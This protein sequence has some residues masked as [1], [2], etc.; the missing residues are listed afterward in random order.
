[1][2]LRIIPT[3]KNA[4]PP[5]V[6]TY[7]GEFGIDLSDLAPEQVAMFVAARNAARYVESLELPVASK[8]EPSHGASL[9]ERELEMIL[10][11]TAHDSAYHETSLPAD[12]MGVGAIGSSHDL[13]RLFPTQWLLE[14]VQPTLFYHKLADGELL[15]P[16]WQR[17]SSGCHN[18]YDD[19]PARDLIDNAATPTARRQHAY[20]L[21]DVSRSMN[22]RDRRG[23]V[24]RGLALA[25]LR[26]G[27]RGRCHLNCRPFNA[28]VQAL[29]SGRGEGALEQLARRIIAL[30]NAGQ[31]RIQ[32][33]LETA[34]QDVR[35][36]GPCRRADIML[37]SDGISR[38]TRCPLSR[39]ALHT[40][41][42]GELPESSREPRQ[43]MVLPHE[44]VNLSQAAARTGDPAS[45]GTEADSIAVLEGW[46]KSFHQVGAPEFTRLLTPS[47][48]DV[49]AA[50][51]LLRE[52]ME[53]LDPDSTLDIADALHRLHRNAAFLLEQWKRIHGREHSLPEEE[54]TLKQ[55]LASAAGHDGS[56]DGNPASLQGSTR[57]L[58]APCGKGSELLRRSARHQ[59]RR[60]SNEQTALFSSHSSGAT[61]AGPSG[62]I[63]LLAQMLW[64]LRKLSG[65]LRRLLRL[66]LRDRSNADEPPQN[67]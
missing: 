34:V 53:R 12:D 3:P 35:R 26:H 43:A 37:I 52:R 6:V 25:F 61:A 32:A 47:R 49:Q 28:E 29:S 7:L 48:A 23:T 20:V 54:T 22:D 16:V 33:A 17:P 45:G 44:H 19:T 60:S 63:S 40:F 2:P 15:M 27:Q 50:T 57:A 8:P 13:P 42:L 11:R 4:T 38:L 9:A 31:T 46:S 55:Y 51:R 58:A 67:R 21:L 18:S 65:L 14:D 1:M 36:T 41:I 39:E 62:S 56:V 64:P 59:A 30:P 66:R 5:E 24:A 10:Q